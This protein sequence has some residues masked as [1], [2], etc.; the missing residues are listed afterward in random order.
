M[1]TA[2]DRREVMELYAA[3]FGERPLIGESPELYISPEKLIVGSACV[4]RSHF[5]P[6]KVFNS[7]LHVLP[8]ICHTLEAILHCVQLQWLCILVGPYSSGKT[9]LIRLLAQLTGNLLVE[10]N[11]SSG[12]DVSELLGCFEQ[13]NSFRIC[14][15][16][17]TQVEHYVDEYFAL[18]LEL[19]WK[20]LIK[21]R[22]SLFAKWFA[23]LAASNY[24]SS[25]STSEFAMSWND[26]SCR[27]LSPLI[28]IIELLKG[29]LEKFNLP[30]S[31]SYNDLNRTQKIVLK[32]QLNKNLQQPAKF[33][34]VA[35]DLIKAIE[36][37]EW[38]VL[39][40]ANLCNPTV[41]LS[42]LSRHAINNFSTLMHCFSFC[43]C[44]Y[45][46]T[47]SIH[48]LISRFLIGLILW[49]NLMGLSRLMNVV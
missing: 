23:F 2:A 44:I 17:I 16:V 43:T 18:R 12:T 40:N 24:N 15:E 31:W 13:Y 6:I 25:M 39:E 47:I 26:G 20:S 11:L 32:L 10:L 8:G 27:S 36:R 48:F 3:V 37:G 5:Q 45:G 1:R 38:V 22:K 41:C 28:E 33:E 7:Q 4:E 9:S 49:W 21:E 42:S 30:V 19:G 46:I 34:W 14:R 29:D 35:G